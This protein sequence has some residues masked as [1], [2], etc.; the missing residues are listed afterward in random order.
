MSYEISIEEKAKLYAERV[1]SGNFPIE[2]SRE[3][4]VK[5]TA[6]DFMAKKMAMSD[7]LK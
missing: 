6:N 5:H 1:C 4:V 7:K 2:Y 3:Q